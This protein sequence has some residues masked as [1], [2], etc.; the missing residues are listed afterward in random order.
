MVMRLGGQVARALPFFMLLYWTGWNSSVN[1]SQ[2]NHADTQVSGEGGREG[3]PGA[4]AEVL[5]QPVVKTT[6]RQAVPCSP[7]R[8]T[9]EQ[10]DA[11]RT[12]PTLEQFVKNC[13]PWE[14]PHTGAGEEYEESSP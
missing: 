12:G 3:A 11:R 14:G 13:S 7:W 4:G 1:S 5:L 8:L 9:P 6:V 2:N 10:V